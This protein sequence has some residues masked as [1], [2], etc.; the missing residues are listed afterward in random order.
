MFVPI[1]SHDE[2]G[3]ALFGVEA[4]LKDVAFYPP[5]FTAAFGSRPR[6]RASGLRRRWRSSCN[7]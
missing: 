3:M 4:K 2:Q 6:S 7:R 5:L 1:D